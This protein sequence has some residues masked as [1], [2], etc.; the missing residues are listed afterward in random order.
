MKKIL[1]HSVFS[2][3]LIMVLIFATTSITHAQISVSAEY[4][5]DYMVRVT[6]TY[7][8]APTTPPTESDFVFTSTDS[9]TPVTTTVTFTDGDDNDPLTYVITWSDLPSVGF[10]IITDLS[11]TLITYLPVSWSLT[12]APSQNNHVLNYNGGLMGGANGTLRA[13][14]NLIRAGAY[15]LIASND[16][17][18]DNGTVFPTMPR[19]TPD[20]IRKVAWSDVSDEPDM[21]DLYSLFQDGGTLN[22]R[23]NEIGTTNRVGSKMNDGTYDDN[24]GRNQRQVVINE[25]MWANDE[26]FLGSVEEA[27]EQWIELYVRG[28]VL[29]N[30]G[31]IRLST[32]K[33]W[34]AP[35]PETDRLSNVSSLSNVW[36]IDS[37]GQHGNSGSPRIEFK[38][39]QRIERDDDNYGDGSLAGNWEAGS[40]LYLRNY[41]GTPG[42]QNIA[43]RL[44][45]PRRKPS[46]DS[47]SINSIIINEIGNF[48]DDTADW[49]ELRN[50]TN[51][52][53]DLAGWALTKTIGFGNEEEIIRFDEDSELEIPARGVLLLVNDDP[54][55]T[56]LTAGY[57]V[58]IEA[59]NQVFN[60]APHQYLIVEDNKI[61]IPNDD[62]W[63]LILRNN[64]PWDVG[65]GNN[66]YQTGYQVQDA[67]GP[68]AAHEAFVKMD[69][70]VLTGDFEKDSDGKAGDQE[71]GN[72][73][74]HTKVFPLNGNLQD[75]GDLLQAGILDTAGKVWVRDD[76]K[77]GFLKDA[78]TEAEFTGIGYDRR[79][80]ANARY[81]GTPGY[82]NDVA[83]EKLT[84]LDGG[85]LIISELMLTT[86]NN[87]YPQWIELYNTSKTRGID[88]AKD[89][90]NPKTGWQLII[91]NHNSGSW[92]ED[93]RELNIEINL[94]DLFDYYIPPNQTVLIVSS[95]GRSSDNDH[96]PD[97]RTASIYDRMRNE[98]SMD[99]RRDSILNVEGGFYIKIVD[100]EGS[101]SDEV[102]NLDGVAVDIRRGIGYDDPFSWNWSTEMSEDG[103]RTSLIRL[104]DDNGRPRIAIPDRSEEGSLRGAVLPLGMNTRPSGY[105][106]VHAVDTKLRVPDVWY[107]NSGDNGT[108]GY[109]L[110][111]ALPV[112]LSFFRPTLENGEVVIHW[113]TESEVDNAG[114]NILRSKDRFGEFVQVNSQL[115]QG[116]GTSGERRTYK[117]VD[118]TAK[119]GVVYYYQIE[120]VSYAGEHQVIT[121]TRLKGLISAKNKLSTTWSDLK[122]SR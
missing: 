12:S 86:D 69:L 71:D 99:N 28:D 73:V 120:D 30:I 119:P 37:K 94:K 76:S 112:S 106:W 14:P 8:E 34:P 87:K 50:V 116:A 103:K 5:P 25:V 62:Q 10:V 1:S 68:G 53:Q 72:Q 80:A 84:Q 101:V 29:F 47:A 32:S 78:W 104:R 54:R 105:A 57:D 23:L 13:D 59:D 70:D 61:D 42:E 108:P 36:E 38:S 43:A 115:I 40:R 24:I 96:F 15:L 2:L 109:I 98:F 75:D 7:S 100:G 46:K 67:V 92:D 102:G 89:N 79:V 63:L 66:V 58:S 111:T 88:L 45:T 82:D 60:T 51:S 81:G 35:P 44:P 91:E 122:N 11:F 26:R 113:T 9:G 20:G 4:V 22:L 90:S 16:D 52:T 121:T 17:A 65:D 33:T 27:Q 95:K 64:T 114:F 56:A 97:S 83:K 107:G 39:M 21:P 41:R 18:I 48:S 55:N 85:R 118:T 110:G 117:W 74:W 6:L 19:V 77:Q 3:L 49:I 93:N 31:D